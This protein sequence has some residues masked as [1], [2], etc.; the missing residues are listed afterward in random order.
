M[1]LWQIIRQG[2]GVSRK[3]RLL[4]NTP[5]V[6]PTEYPLSASLSQSMCAQIAQLLQRG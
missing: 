5:V 3:S 4:I 1:N 2:V 6:I